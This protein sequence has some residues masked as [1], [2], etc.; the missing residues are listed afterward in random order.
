MAIDYVFFGPNTSTPTIDTS[1]LIWDT[2]GKL[3]I[4]TSSPGSTLDVNGAGN[5]T[6]SITAKTLTVGNSVVNYLTANVDA[7]GVTGSGINDVLELTGGYLESAGDATGLRFVQRDTADDYGAAIRLVNT[8]GSPSYL[9]PRLDILVQTTD[10]S[11]ISSLTNVASFFGSGHV[12]I[13][14]TVDSALLS[15]GNGSI[16]I[17]GSPFADASRNI[18]ATTGTFAGAVIANGGINPNA[19]GG[20]NLDTYLENTFVGNVSKTY[21]PTSTDATISYVIVGN[22]VTPKWLDAGS[23]RR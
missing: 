8:A 7:N 2:S 1:N 17:N 15:V 10:T 12:G 18:T 23:T 21:F 22:Q 14:T 9:N 11:V 6:G 5:F 3:G 19:S 4:G 13:G 20:Y 16:Y